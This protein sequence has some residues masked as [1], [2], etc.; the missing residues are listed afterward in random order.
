MKCKS[1]KGY[2]SKYTYAGHCIYTSHVILTL[3]CVLLT[4]MDVKICLSHLLCVSL[5]LTICMTIL[6]QLH[7]TISC[8]SIHLQCTQP[9][10]CMVPCMASCLYRNLHAV[11][12][13]ATKG[14]R[15]GQTIQIYRKFI[16][17]CIWFSMYSG[18]L[19]LTAIELQHEIPMYVCISLVPRPLQLF[20]RAYVEKAEKAWVRGYVYIYS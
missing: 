16:Y 8:V 13:Q 1:H 12:V 9:G 17:R 4:N 20:S 19:T 18:Y 14:M 6:L 15:K 3:T 11:N 2:T 5:T 10:Q 7:N